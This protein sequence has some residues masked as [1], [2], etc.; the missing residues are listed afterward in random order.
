MVCGHRGRETNQNCVAAEVY[1]AEN[2]TRHEDRKHA[3][4]AEKSQKTRV[5]AEKLGEAKILF[6]FFFFVR[7]ILR[8][9]DATYVPFF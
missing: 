7:R 1:G 6:V 9:R 3:V 8:K 4:T 5:T 2:N